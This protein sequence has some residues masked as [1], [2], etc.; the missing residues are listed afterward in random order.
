ML[1]KSTAAFL[2]LSQPRSTSIYRKYFKIYQH[3]QTFTFQ[4]SQQEID[5]LVIKN[6]IECSVN[7]QL[8]AQPRIEVMWECHMSTLTSV[9]CLADLWPPVRAHFKWRLLDYQWD[10]IKV[11]KKKRFIIK[12]KININIIFLFKRYNFQLL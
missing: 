5:R 4:N 7:W 6:T 2:T 9:K 11:N 12:K 1:W 10:I 8:V 3:Y